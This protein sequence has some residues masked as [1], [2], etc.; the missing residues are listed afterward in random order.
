MPPEHSAKAVGL[1]YVTDE[2]PGLKRLKSKVTF[3]Y[4]DARGKAVRAKATLKRI[5]S[6]AIPPA[7]TEVWICPHEHGHLQATGRD[8]R[9]RK[10]HRYHPLWR[11]VRDATKFDHLIQFGRTLPKI[12]RQ[13]ARDLSRDELH[14]EKVLAT[15][16]RLMDLTLIRVGNHEY[17][18][19]NNSYGLTTFKD[20][21]AIVRGGR[22]QFSFRGK[23]GK[24][25]KI[26]IEDQRLAKIV[27][28]CQDIPGQRLFQYYNG[29]GNRHD[30]T[31]GDVNDYLREISGADFTAKDFRT[32]TA[33]VLATLALKQAPPFQTSRQAKSNIK[34]A[35]ETVAEKLGNTPAI[36]QKCYVDPLVIDSY[37]RGQLKGVVGNGAKKSIRR[38]MTSLDRG[39][40]DVLRFL[41]SCHRPKRHSIRL[42]RP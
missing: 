37:E 19:Q 30:V 25:H 28:R 40:R 26:E 20:R 41:R 16:I 12:R 27:K 29:D 9:K 11:E 3:R 14:R 18:K 23:S 24:E 38:F 7:W 8:A 22:I 13:V 35:I 33:T 2:Q 17:A 39:E 21:H 15:I 34:R 1:R 6:L 32:W 4:V 5:R 31:S 42:S 36:C 10:Q